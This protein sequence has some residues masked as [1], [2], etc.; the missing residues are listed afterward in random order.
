[1]FLAQFSS[2]ETNLGH[3]CMK[4]A[5]ES[6]VKYAGRQKLA[7]RGKGDDR[8]CIG[9]LDGPPNCT[10][11][12][13]KLTSGNSQGAGRNGSKESSKNGTTSLMRTAEQQTTL[14]MSC[15]IFNRQ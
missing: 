7:L 10:S 11:N 12:R 15:R 9:E 8:V 2:D 3:V 13:L 1:M 14:W 5:L 4:D 6:I